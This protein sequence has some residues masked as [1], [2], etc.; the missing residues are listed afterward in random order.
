ME[1]S[2]S[3]VLPIW[4]RSHEGSLEIH[5]NAPAAPN[6]T[7]LSTVRPVCNTA[8]VS[9]DFAKLT[10]VELFEHPNTFPFL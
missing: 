6:H 8:V 9:M 3:A 2:D 1:V 10:R 4:F 7:P 5:I